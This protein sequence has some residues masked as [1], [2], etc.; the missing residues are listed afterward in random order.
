MATTLAPLAPGT[1]TE[2]QHEVY[3]LIRKA[4]GVIDNKAIA[5]ELG[6]T[7][8]NVAQ[9]VRKMRMR[10]VLPEAAARGN[11]GQAAP[12]RR[13]TPAATPPPA[14]EPPDP[15]DAPVAYTELVNDV[16]EQ[17]AKFI[18]GAKERLATIET[19]IGELDHEQE[20]RI[21]SYDR[22]REALVKAGEHLAAQIRGLGG[23]I[24]AQ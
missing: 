12:R 23:A 16:D 1:L 21:A 24:E 13:S 3:E 4:D 22:Q 10:G 14:P 9:H 7:T 18:A 2:K 17:A 11:D 8:N 5:T 19:T 15:E 20:A 6:T